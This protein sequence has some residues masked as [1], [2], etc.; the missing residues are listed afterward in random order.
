MIEAITQLD[1]RILTF[2]RDNL[3]FSFGD[4]FFK[5]ITHMAD[6]IVAPVYPIILIIIGSLIYWNRHKKGLRVLDPGDRFDFARLGWTMGVALL[7]G[8]VICNFTL[9]PLIARVRPYE[10]EVFKGVLPE[11]RIIELQSEKSF[12]SGH[13]V[14]V[15]EMALVVSWYC[16][17]MHRGVWGFV[18]YAAAILIAFS[19]IYV[20]VH[21]PSDVLGGFVIGTVC[22]ILAILIVNAIYKKLESKYKVTVV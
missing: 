3:R 6:P 19:R 20:G 21:Y 9:K 13:S 10:L 4:A 16:K 17:R 8:L 1:V 7:I 22:G 11:L 2:V 15:F 18:A 12:P 5:V 14:A